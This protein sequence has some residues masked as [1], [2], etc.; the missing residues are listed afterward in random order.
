MTA[1]FTKSI[2]GEFENK[3]KNN[4]FNFDSLNLKISF[5]IFISEPWYKFLN[6]RNLREAVPC[7]RS[8]WIGSR[9]NHYDTM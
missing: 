6:L 7:W 4:L 3:I 2:Y 1:D 5:S 9:I 8:N